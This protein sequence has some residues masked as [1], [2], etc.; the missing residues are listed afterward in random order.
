MATSITIEKIEN[1]KIIGEGIVDI[2][3]GAVL[4]ATNS[5][6]QESTTSINT[7]STTTPITTTDTTTTI[8]NTTTRTVATATIN[9]TLTTTSPTTT[10][11]T[12][13]TTT[14][15]TRTDDYYSNKA[16]RKNGRLCSSSSVQPPCAPAPGAP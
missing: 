9:T 13:N 4:G 14:I 5:A 3:K 15:T 11:T 2:D 10:Y 8:I 6:N 16:R 7:T 12:T 1:N